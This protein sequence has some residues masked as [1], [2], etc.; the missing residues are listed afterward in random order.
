MQGFQKGGVEAA[1][2]L[3]VSLDHGADARFALVETTGKLGRE[4]LLFHFRAQVLRP[5]EKIA[6]VE[7][8]VSEKAR[9]RRLN[10]GDTDAWKNRGHTAE[11]L[12]IDDLR[13]G[14]VGHFR[15]A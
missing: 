3:L 10:D 6:D 9:D 15:G 1:E 8:V 5:G 12:A 4:R 7:A 11:D 14:H 13:L 2:R